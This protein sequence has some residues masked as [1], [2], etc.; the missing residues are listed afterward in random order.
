[1]E[2]IFS[3][4]WITLTLFLSL[5]HNPGTVLLGIL[6]AAICFQVA[7]LQWKKRHPNSYTLTS[8]LLLW[9]L[10]LFI[11][12]SNGFWRFILLWS[13]Y[14]VLNVAVLKMTHGNKINPTTPRFVY[15]LYRGA[16]NVTMGIAGFGYGL[17]LVNLFAFPSAMVIDWSLN[18][19]FYGLY[20]GVLSRDFVDY[21]AGKMASALGV[22]FVLNLFHC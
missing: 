7:L 5:V 17:F 9:I 2:S 22:Y 4:L 13:I 10:P 3:I 1:M 11:S 19:V 20:F 14:S 18:L 12:L 8:L 15:R 16:F 21:I 6:L